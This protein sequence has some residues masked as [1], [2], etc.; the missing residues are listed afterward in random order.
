MLFP[1]PEEHGIRR[2][3]QKDAVQ[4]PLRP[5]LR[6]HLGEAVVAEVFH[7]HHAEA[8]EALKD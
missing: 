8:L 5:R 2:E 4:V 1:A 3:A 7:H 6:L